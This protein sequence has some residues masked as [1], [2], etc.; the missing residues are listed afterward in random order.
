MY[1]YYKYTKPHN[2]INY[3]GDSN[4][5]NTRIYRHYGSNTFDSNHI[6]CDRGRLKPSGLY[7][8]PQNS[9]KFLTWKDMIINI[10]KYDEEK[11]RLETL[12]K[13]FDFR[14]SKDARILKI[15]RITDIKDYIIPDENE[16]NDCRIREWDITEG[17]LLNL[18][19]LYRDYDA[20]LLIHGNNY[21]ELCFSHL[22]YEWDVDSICVWN[23][24]KVIP[25]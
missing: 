5:P 8:S 10:C 12:N 3:K 2:K 18:E 9:K 17:Q 7:A 23:L 20:M 25:L 15:R 14:L 11:W 21:N 24:D 16:C 1:I 13:Y 19:K 6:Y 4:M 22:F